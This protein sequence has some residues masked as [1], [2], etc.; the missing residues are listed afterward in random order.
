[1][2]TYLQYVYEMADLRNYVDKLYI[3]LQE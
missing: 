1:M 3:A 2:F